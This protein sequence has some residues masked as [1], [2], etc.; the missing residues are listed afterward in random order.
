MAKTRLPADLQAW[1]DARK[2]YHLS[3]AHIQMSR[4][5][6]M[7]PKKFGG[8]ANHRQE[9]WKVPLPQFIEELYE[10]RFGKLRPG[11]VIS[12]EERA[13]EIAAKKAA[14]REARAKTRQEHEGKN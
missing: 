10:R 7:N 3:H 8:L 5:L 9:P 13:K 4:E 14:R 2:R 12:I 6:G 1:I 11:R